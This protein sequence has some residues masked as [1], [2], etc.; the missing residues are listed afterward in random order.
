MATKRICLQNGGFCKNPAVSR[1]TRNRA[2]CNRIVLIILWSVL[3]RRNAIIQLF[4]DD[5]PETVRLVKEQLAQGGREIVDELEE[6]VAEP[7][8]TVSQHA[9]E[10]LHTV[11]QQDA[12]EDLTL[13]CFFFDDTHN[14]EHICW[15]LSRCI[16]PEVDTRPY[17]ALIKDWGRK[18]LLRSS[19]AISSRERVT[20]LVQFVHDE[21]GFCGNTDEYYSEKNS[22]LPWV[23]NMRRGI[24]ISLT[25]LYMFIAERA[26]M[27][28]SGVNL[29]GHFIAKHGSVF[30]DPYNAGKFLD[31]ADCEK[32]L[33]SQRLALSD[34]HLEPATPRQIFIRMLVN[35]LYLYDLQGN[36]EKY[37]QINSWL[38][39]LTNPFLNPRRR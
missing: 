3:T 20:K 33:C 7:D 27:K 31:R 18:F 14:L 4:Q 9:T 2:P 8:L 37:S 12:K 30:F 26:G 10:V 16:Q 17:K 6:L 29:P 19:E 28:V 36:R 21:L 23:I 22:L 13:L 35:L 11:L 34:R 25:L 39:V 24:P 5:D 1:N 38:Q 15:T 32:I